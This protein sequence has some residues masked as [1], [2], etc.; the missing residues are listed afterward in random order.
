MNAID[1]AV[2]RIQEL[3]LAMSSISIKSAPDYPIENA[4][5]FP[6]VASFPT[7]GE[8][9]VDNASLM[10]NF[11]VVRIEFHLSRV[12][13]KQ[14]QQQINAIVYEFPRRLAGD[15]T[16]NAT[17]DTSKMTRDEP[18]TYTTVVSDWGAVKS[19]TMVFSLPLKLRLAPQVTA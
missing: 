18:V 2:A 6:F 10:H 8:F 1:N 12:N 19:H 7:S 13:I 15:P 14:M 4:D 3:A 17:I 9:W 16:L 5:P 11:P